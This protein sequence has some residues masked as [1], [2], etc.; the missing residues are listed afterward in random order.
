M[1]GRR[2]FFSRTFGVALGV[3][4]AMDLLL[5]VA[6]SPD[7]SHVFP[8]CDVCKGL[9]VK[10]VCDLV[11]D[12]LPEDEWEQWCPTG[13]RRNGCPEHPVEIRYYAPHEVPR[14]APWWASKRSD[15]FQHLR[16]A[17]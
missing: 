7:Q 14:Y 10:V 17:A 2:S 15:R 4:F 3:P 8:P 5:T 13:I 12:K 1:N 11:M 9:T 16:P 6:P